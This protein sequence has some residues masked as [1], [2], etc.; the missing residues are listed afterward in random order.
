MKKDWTIL[1]SVRTA[2]LLLCALCVVA[3]GAYSFFS[4][5]M[6]A[7]EPDAPQAGSMDA[8]GRLERGC[9]LDQTLQY[10]VCGHHVERR[11]DA[12]D[13]VLGMNRELFAQ[14]MADWRITSFASQK[15]EMT[16]TMEMACPAHWVIAAD[17]DGKL[18]VYR[19]LYGE[20]MVCLRALDIGVSTAPE[21]DAAALRVGMCFDTEEAAEGYLEAIQS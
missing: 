18:G 15:V 19:N 3:A 14:A 11:I 1:L 7:E 6:P 8:Q 21:S 10:A 12:P 2:A 4:P 9:V 20:E 17:A 13:T 16:R 5:G